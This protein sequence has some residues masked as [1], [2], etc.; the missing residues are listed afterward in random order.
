MITHHR[1]VSTTNH[2]TAKQSRYGCI[3]LGCGASERNG[4]LLVSCKTF[5]YDHHVR[6]WRVCLSTMHTRTNF[7]VNKCFPD[8]ILHVNPI[9]PRYLKEVQKQDY[10]DLLTDTITP[11]SP[12]DSPFCGYRARV[13]FANSFQFHAL[14]TASSESKIYWR[15]LCRLN[16]PS[17]IPARLWPAITVCG[18][19]ASIASSAGSHSWLFS[20]VL[21]PPKY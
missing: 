19:S 12:C 7:I 21:A 16:S 18:S 14:A 9:G 3:R 8:E 15:V 13:S 6:L 10:N 4:N 1:R 11:S 20:V 2:T 17:T 5:D